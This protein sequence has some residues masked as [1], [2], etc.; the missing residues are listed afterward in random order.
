MSNNLSSLFKRYIKTPNPTKDHAVLSASGSERWMGCPGSIR[1]SQGIPPVDNEAS[2]QGTHAHTLLQFILENPLD[3]RRLLAS[4][5]ARAFLKHIHFS[6]DQLTSVLVAVCYVHTEMKKTKNVELY[7]EQK[8]ELKGVGFGTADIIL[9]Q[10]F[11]LLHIL[12]Y[13]NGAYPVSPENNKQGLYYAVAAADRFGWDF[14]KVQITIIQ[15]NIKTMRAHPINTWST[16]RTE[17]ENAQKAFSVAARATRNNQAPLIPNH[18]YCWFCPARS[19]CPE[20]M[21]QKEVKIMDRFTRQ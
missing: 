21:K 12:D 4:K 14:N 1:L 7:T 9:Y 16:S 2:L 3:W 8:L 18:K 15:P 13:K 17:L 11:G 5:E 20:Q 10:P 19:I 6:Q